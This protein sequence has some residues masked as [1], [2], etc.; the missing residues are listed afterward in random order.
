MTKGTPIY[1]Q[2]PLMCF[3]T[4]E[5]SQ[6]LKLL[7]LKVPSFVT[8]KFPP[9]HLLLELKTNPFYIYRHHSTRLA[10][11][12]T[13]LWT[14]RLA[15]QVGKQVKQPLYLSCPSRNNLAAYIPC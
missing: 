8:L 13:T 9:F 7:T 2:C 15:K 3:P 10:L 14:K 6:K 11:Q 5:F 12:T 4:L 1:H